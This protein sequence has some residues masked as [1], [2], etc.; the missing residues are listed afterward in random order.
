MIMKRRDGVECI[1]DVQVGQ[2]TKAAK[3]RPRNDLEGGF[4]MTRSILTVSLRAVIE[5]IVLFDELFQ[6]VGGV[7]PDAEL[8]EIIRKMISKKVKLPV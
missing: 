7:G 8:R 4:S 2:L 3:W 5:A 6:R 1:Y